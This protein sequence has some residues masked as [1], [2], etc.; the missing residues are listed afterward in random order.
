[1]N[2]SYELEYYFLAA[3]NITMAATIDSDKL[4]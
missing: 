2:N 1:L 4:V 3:N